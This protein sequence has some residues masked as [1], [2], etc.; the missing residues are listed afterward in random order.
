MHVPAHTSG[1]P[2]TQCQHTDPIC[3]MQTWPH[4]QAMQ[5]LVSLVPVLHEA[6]NTGDLSWWQGQTLIL[7]LGSCSCASRHTASATHFCR[8]AETAFGQCQLL[9]L[10]HS[11]ITILATSVILLLAEITLMLFCTLNVCKVQ[12]LTSCK[13]GC[14]VL[15]DGSMQGLATTCCGQLQIK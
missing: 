5:H 15:K 6:V 9:G 3:Q 10:C 14:I 12:F 8:S 7:C 1:G 4:S 13:C 11:S 2:S